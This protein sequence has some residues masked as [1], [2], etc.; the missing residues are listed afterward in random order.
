MTVARTIIVCLC[1]AALVACG[2]NE[3]A[4]GPVAGKRQPPVEL[5]LVD[6]RPAPSVLA[7]QQVLHRDNGEEPQTLDPHLAEGVPAANILRDLYEGLT[8]ESPEGRVVPGAAERWNISRD[9]RI[10]TV[11]GRPGEFR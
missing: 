7:E 11:P 4:P 5:V 1:L 3:G 6:G 8:A 2:G 9:G 10:Y